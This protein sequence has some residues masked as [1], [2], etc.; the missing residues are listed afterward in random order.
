MAT[1]SGRAISFPLVDRVPRRG[2]A[3]VRLGRRQ[4]QRTFALERFQILQTVKRLRLVV[5]RRWRVIGDAAGLHVFPLSMM[6]IF[7]VGDIYQIYGAENSTDGLEEALRRW[8]IPLPV[9]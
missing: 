9:Q 3:Q 5:V 7:S 2:C 1:L 4:Q 6:K 8:F